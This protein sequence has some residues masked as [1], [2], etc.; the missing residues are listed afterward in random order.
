MG[1]MWVV[2]YN[3]EINKSGEKKGVRKK[4]GSCLYAQA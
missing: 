4:V 3:R 1:C 2:I